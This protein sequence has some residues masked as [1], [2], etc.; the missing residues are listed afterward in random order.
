MCAGRRSPPMC[1]AASLALTAWSLFRYVP[2]TPVALIFLGVTPFLVKLF[3]VRL[4]A[5]SRKPRA[6][7]RLRHGLH[8]PD[9]ADRRRRPADRQFFLGGKLDRR[10]IVATK[11]MCQIISHTLKLAYFGGIIEQAGTLDPVLAGLAIVASMVGTT[12]A[13]RFLEMMSDRQYRLWAE[14]HHR[15]HRRLLHHPRHHDADHFGNRRAINATASRSPPPGEGRGWGVVRESE[16]PPPRSLRSR[17]SPQGGGS[18]PT[19][20]IR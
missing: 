2:S 8:D 1:S 7:H 19:P 6:G 17:P 15:D 3:P 5:Q 10:E 4:A 20:I 11:A 13:K 14:P 9:A 18:R 12:A 16:T